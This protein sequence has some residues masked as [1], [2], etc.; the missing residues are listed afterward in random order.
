MGYAAGR[1]WIEYLRIDPVQANNVFGLRL[2]VWTSIIVFLGA[3][4]YF[5]LSARLRPGREELVV[6]NRPETARLSSAVRV[7]RR[8]QSRRRICLG[9]QSLSPVGS[10]HPLRVHNT[11][12][13]SGSTLKA[14]VR[15]FPG[16]TLNRTT[17]RRRMASP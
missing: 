15:R 5:A 12:V 13:R 6:T 10:T 1:G 4:T 8:V 9:G 16:M 17:S 2:N 3:A 14:R 11:A 7:G